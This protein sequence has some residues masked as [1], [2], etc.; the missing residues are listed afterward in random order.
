MYVCVNRIWATF[1]VSSLLLGNPC[2]TF[3]DSDLATLPVPTRTYIVTIVYSLKPV[4][5]SLEEVERLLL[6]R[7]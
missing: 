6:I 3:G 4:T 2:A 5:A 1:F 7:Y